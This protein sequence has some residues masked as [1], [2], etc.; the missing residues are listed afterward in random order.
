MTEANAEVLLEEDDVRGTLALGGLVGFF[1]LVT[2][3][4]YMVHI[5]D[6]VIDDL[7]T[8]ATYVGTFVSTG[9]GWYF[10]A[11]TSSD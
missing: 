4:L 3:M 7:M 8:L 2:A 1:A 11:K 10:G 5:G 6:I 9:V